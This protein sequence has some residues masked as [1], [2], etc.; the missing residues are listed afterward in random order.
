MSQPKR[1][2]L[3]PTQK[4]L[5]H[6]CAGDMIP[7]LKADASVKE[8]RQLAFQHWDKERDEEIQVHVVVVRDPT[9][10]IEPLVTVESR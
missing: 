6:Y 2:P 9:E 3:R 7:M 8:L 5:L 4:H 10:F 1:L